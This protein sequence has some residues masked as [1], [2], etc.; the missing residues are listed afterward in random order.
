MCDDTLAL[1]RDSVSSCGCDVIE[2]RCTDTDRCAEAVQYGVRALPTVVVDG[3]IVF[4][5]RINSAQAALLKR[6]AA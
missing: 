2:R 1:V 4:E 5:G 6:S 3:E